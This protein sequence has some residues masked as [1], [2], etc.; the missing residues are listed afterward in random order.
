ML[1]KIE[2]KYV[3]ANNLYGLTFGKVYNVELFAKNSHIWVRVEGREA[4]IPY[5]APLAFSNNWTVPHGGV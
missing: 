5:S 4:A 3:G 1:D 2:L